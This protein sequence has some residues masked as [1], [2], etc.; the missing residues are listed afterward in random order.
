MNLSSYQGKK[1]KIKLSDNRE[2]EALG[3]DYMY[4]D[5]FEEEYNSLSLI[6]TDVI[7]N[8]QDNKHNL[9]PYLGGKML[10]AIYENQD[11]QITEI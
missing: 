5:D 10:Y 11:I 7:V 2:F 8:G 9:Q 6:I 1:L 4:G 3:I